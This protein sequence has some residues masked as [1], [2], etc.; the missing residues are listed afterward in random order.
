M[1]DSL[2]AISGDVSNTALVLIFKCEPR[3][4]IQLRGAHMHL[5]ALPRRYVPCK[6]YSWLEEMRQDP[7][8]ISFFV[9][10]PEQSLQD[11]NSHMLVFQTVRCHGFKVS[12]IS[13]EKSPQIPEL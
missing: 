11:E 12:T 13:S 7:V 4:H 5:H 1:I 8:P 2:E 3:R 10:L 6:V 9:L